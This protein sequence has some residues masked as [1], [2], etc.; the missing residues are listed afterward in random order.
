M[1]PDGGLLCG[2]GVADLRADAWLSY[3]PITNNAQLTWR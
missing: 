1:P 2:Q 3:M